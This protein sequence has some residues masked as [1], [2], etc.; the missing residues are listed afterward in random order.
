MVDFLDDIA[1]E[2]NKISSEYAI[3]FAHGLKSDMDSTKALELE[4]FCNINHFEFVRY[5]AYGHGKSKGDF[6]DGTISRWVDDCI[7]VIEHVIKAKKIII[8][9]SS[10][11]GWVM[12]KS[13]HSSKLKDRIHALVGIAPAPDFTY[14]M[15]H[16]LFDENIRTMIM[17][18][19]VFNMPTDYEEPLPITKKLIV[20]GNENN[21]LINTEQG[22]KLDFPLRILLGQKDHLISEK[23][24]FKLMKKYQG[25]DVILHLVK[26]GDHSMSRESDIQLLE[27]VIL[28][29]LNIDLDF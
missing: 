12:L 24:I 28:D 7:N 21:L 1:Y 9:G 19:G 5:D 11:G 16:G 26:G 25:E 10:M 22:I 20:D 8:V 18:E 4:K 13:A 29:L 6:L 2:Y 23:N 14:E 27:N 17:E 15:F 3:V